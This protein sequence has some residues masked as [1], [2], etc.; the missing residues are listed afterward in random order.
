[1]YTGNC[2][3]MQ[4]S[5]PPAAGDER[6]NLLHCEELIMTWTLTGEECMMPRDAIIYAQICVLACQFP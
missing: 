3:D 1:M 6:D 5:L 2:V 4:S